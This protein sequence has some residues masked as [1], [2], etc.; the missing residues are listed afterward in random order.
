MVVID[1]VASASVHELSARHTL[2]P[3]AM[4]E[5]SG[6]GGRLTVAGRVFAVAWSGW[7][8]ATTGAGWFSPSYGV[9]LE[10]P[11]L[12]LSATAAAARLAVAFA[13]EGN[14]VALEEWL[15]HELD[16]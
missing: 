5:L 10:A 14:R 3:G 9:K 7:E 6:S 11:V 15:Q 13:P 1:D 16:S 12:E 2:P 4:L 8:E